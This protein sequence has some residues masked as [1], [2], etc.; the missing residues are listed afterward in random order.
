VAAIQ[1]AGGTAVAGLLWL[2]STSRVMWCTVSAL[3][4]QWRQCGAGW[5]SVQYIAPSGSTKPTSIG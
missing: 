5:I 4:S 2:C 3:S 1:A